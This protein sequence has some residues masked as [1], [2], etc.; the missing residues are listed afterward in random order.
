MKCSK[1]PCPDRCDGRQAFCQWMSADNPDP[2]HIR[3]ICYNRKPHTI[4]TGN[5]GSS[6]HHS[7]QGTVIELSKTI[8][9]NK[10]IS[11]CQY[12]YKDGSCGCSSYIC[13]A[14]KKGRPHITHP[15]QT[16]VSFIDC[17]GCLFPEDEDVLRL[18]KSYQDGV[19]NISHVN[20]NGQ[21]DSTKEKSDGVPG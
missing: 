21:P 13:R 5:Q 20:H 15:G 11:E 2:V 8:L 6:D 1:C 18:A 7:R 9:I 4:I 17:A 3:T 14:G 10:K 12:R 16:L 19:A